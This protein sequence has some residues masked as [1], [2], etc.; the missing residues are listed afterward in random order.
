MIK[1]RLAT[2]MK[3]ASWPK[4]NS[5]EV[6]QKLINPKESSDNVKDDLE[7]LLSVLNTKTNVIRL[8]EAETKFIAICTQEQLKG[9]NIK[10]YWDAYQAYKQ[11][12][13]QEK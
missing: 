11:R 7:S 1:I 4:S 3:W 10:P 5:Q 12:T 6:P 13:Y 9:H 2:I 8:G